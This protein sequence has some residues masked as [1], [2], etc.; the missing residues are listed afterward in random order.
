MVVVLL[1][2]PGV[3][4]GTQGALLTEDLGWEWISTGDLLRRAQR[5]GT[6]LG[7][8]AQAYMEAGDLVPDELILAMMK[9]GLEAL[10]PG[11]GVVLDGFP[12]NLH[13][14]RE[15]DRMLPEVSRKVDGVVLLEAPA[16]VLVKRLSGRR[17]CPECG[18]VYN[19]HFD[20]PSTPGQC[21]ACGARLVHREDDDVGTVEHRLEVYRARTEPLVAYY[22]ESPARVL[23]IDGDRPP[24]EV[25][26]GV[27]NALR[28][29]LGVEASDR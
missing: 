21:D 27:R 14:A 8:K 19:V 1:G 15:L 24:E 17:S 20:P 3:G 9:E 6:E 25:R 11:T 2:P 12:R 5:E 29:E 23:R 7:R 13:Q 16:E 22:E 28:S 26:D 10:D 18:R 4:K